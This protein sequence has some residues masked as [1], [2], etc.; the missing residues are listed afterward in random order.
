MIIPYDFPEDLIE[1]IYSLIIYKVDINLLEDIKDYYKVNEKIKYIDKQLIAYKLLEYKYIDFTVPKAILNYFCDD[2]F[3]NINYLV[4]RCLR[5]NN[6][7]KREII[8]FRL[9]KDILN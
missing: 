8:L 9:S 1:Y 2:T 5:K 7:I 6:I 4:N 3:N